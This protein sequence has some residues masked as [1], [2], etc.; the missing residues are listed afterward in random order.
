M[1]SAG[2][3]SC[4]AS[5][6]SSKEKKNLREVYEYLSK[7]RIDK[8]PI[9]RRA[10]NVFVVDIEASELRMEERAGQQSQKGTVMGYCSCGAAYP[11]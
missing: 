2:I 1:V 11:P 3:T 5:V 4:S 7:N 8:I 9:L 6:R 10:G